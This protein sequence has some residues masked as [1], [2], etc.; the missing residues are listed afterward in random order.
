ME[1][2][3]YLN[4]VRRRWRLILATTLVGAVVA[5][6][7]TVGMTKQYESQARIFF[8][9]S[10]QNLSEAYQGGNFAIQRVASY[11]HVVEGNQLSARVINRLKLDL[12][13]EELDEKVTAT[14]V[15]DT[16]ILDISV[17]DSDPKKAQQIAQATA[18]ELRRTVSRLETPPGKGAAPIRATVF[19]SADLPDSPVSP[20]PL[21]NIGLGLLL[22]LLLGAGAALLRELS[23]KNSESDTYDEIAFEEPVDER[24]AFDDFVDPADESADPRREEIGVR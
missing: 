10:D 4:V 11:A 20:R 6:A 15:P 8:T 5:A 18:A 9:T 2:V 7:L 19:D 13:P 24:S 21:V 3:D 1:L 16:V 17:T 14:A 12:T 23:T 22:G